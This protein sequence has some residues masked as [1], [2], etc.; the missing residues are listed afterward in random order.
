VV[1]NSHASH[2][3]TP[4]LVARFAAARERF[5]TISGESS[6]NPPVARSGG[7][8]DGE[9]KSPTSLSTLLGGIDDRL[10]H[11]AH[12]ERGNAGPPLHLY[13]TTSTPHGDVVTATPEFVA[14]MRRAF[15][16]YG[17]GLLGTVAVARGEAPATGDGEGLE[18][19][20]HRAQFLQSP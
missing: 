19:K 2:G 18:V 10:I 9:S 4:E 12:A 3:L 14:Y 15:P 7:I 5:K 17:G 16:G 1:R 13:R 20:P 11:L 8:Q 6:T